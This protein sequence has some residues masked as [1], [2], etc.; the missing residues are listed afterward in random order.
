MGTDMAE[1]V[2]AVMDASLQL[3]T[4]TFLLFFSAAVLVLICNHFGLVDLAALD[5]RAWDST[6]SLALGSAA[7]AFSEVLANLLTLHRRKRLLAS[8]KGG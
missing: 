4:I 6:I 2:R 8:W 1:H 5:P 3:S 7:L